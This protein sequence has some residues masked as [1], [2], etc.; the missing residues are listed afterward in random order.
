MSI[1]PA[2]FL[3]SADLALLGN[4]VDPSQ[5]RRRSQRRHS[6]RR[7]IAAVNRSLAIV[8]EQISTLYAASMAQPRP[9]TCT[10][11]C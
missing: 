1:I 8:G 11:A 4:N 10:V 6:H 9:A 5:R 7:E 2:R 3:S